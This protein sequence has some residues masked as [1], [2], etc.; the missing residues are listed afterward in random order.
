VKALL[1][2]VV[3]AACGTDA[4]PISVVVPGQQAL[5]TAKLGTAGWKAIAGTYDANT[6]AT[7]YQ[8]AIS[9][10][11]ELV[12]VCQRQSGTFAATNLLGTADDAE[13]TLGSWKAPDCVKTP[14]GVRPPPTDQLVTITGM[15]PPNTTIAVDYSK[16]VVNTTPFS[17]TTWP[18]IHD[19][20][21]YGNAQ[22]L[23][24]HD[25]DLGEHP[26]LGAVPLIEQG[27]QVLSATYDLSGVGTDD[28]TV[29][30]QTQ[31]STRNGTY[32]YWI[33]PPGSPTFMPPSELAAGDE[34]LFSISFSASDGMS[35]RYAHVTS[36]DPVPTS[37]D[38]LPRL[39]PAT[40]PAGLVSATW[41]PLTEFYT[42]V[43]VIGQQNSSIQSVTA[44]KLWMERHSTTQ[45]AF[46]LAVDGYDPAWLL[47]AP[48]LNVQ[49][50][51]WT[52]GLELYS[53]VIPT[54]AP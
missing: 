16:H 26:D 44:S 14:G 37:F 22:I 51:R 54:A 13:V 11:F 29:I 3:I 12:V 39:G 6:N 35:A 23:I 49:A 15:A 36:F 28:E 20:I 17:F 33:D 8:I 9:G 40:A 27:A 21:A 25:V 46:D 52:Q 7:T 30:A 45:L 19:V 38:F 50:E 18:G 2:A 5:F 32:F 48:T 53:S 10:D 31:I 4:A 42:T 34:Q 43:S 1:L 47:D 41:T 24:T